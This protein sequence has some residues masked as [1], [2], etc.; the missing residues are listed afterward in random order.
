LVHESL[1]SDPATALAKAMRWVALALS[2]LFLA[3]LLDWF[4]ELLAAPVD[5]LV[6]L[7]PVTAPDQAVLLGQ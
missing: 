4:V 1:Q 3:A 5:S 7:F 2:P 6:E